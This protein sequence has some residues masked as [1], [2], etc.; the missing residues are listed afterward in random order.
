MTLVAAHWRAGVLDLSDAETGD[1]FFVVVGLEGREV[2][3]RAVLR[4]VEH[5]EGDADAVD[6]GRVGL[7][8]KVEDQALCA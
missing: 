2:V 8:V 6:F 3:G 7:T 1:T 4:R 5:V